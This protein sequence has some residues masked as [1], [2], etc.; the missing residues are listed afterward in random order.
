M[1]NERILIIGGA[2]SLGTE[3]VKELV[4]LKV[5]NNRITHDVYGKDRADAVAASVW[6]A[7]GEGPSLTQ[8]LVQETM[9]EMYGRESGG[10]TYSAVP[11]KW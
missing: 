4:Y 2:G 9:G 11:L 6:A 1:E 3:L 5:E 10:A 8:R 7:T